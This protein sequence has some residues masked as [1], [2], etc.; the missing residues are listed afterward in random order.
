[1]RPLSYLSLGLILAGA[2]FFGPSLMAAPGDGDYFLKEAVK[3]AELVRSGH[4]YVWILVCSS[5]F[6]PHNDVHRSVM[7]AY[8]AI[9][10]IVL[11]VFQCTY[12][13]HPLTGRQL[14]SSMGVLAVLLVHRDSLVAVFGKLA[15]RFNES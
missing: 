1:M 9:K 2:D 8:K 12:F 13:T 3:V 14:P 11:N 5:Q 15:C 7:C 10:R 4:V 6:P